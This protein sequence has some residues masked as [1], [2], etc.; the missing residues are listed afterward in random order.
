MEDKTYAVRRE[1]LTNI[2]QRFGKRPKNIL[3]KEIKDRGVY[4]I[5]QS[6]EEVYELAK[7]FSEYHNIPFGY[8]EPIIKQEDEFA[9]FKVDENVF[10]EAVENIEQD[11]FYI[12]LIK[13]RDNFSKKLLAL[14]KLIETY[15]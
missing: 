9:S 1:I 12:S 7:K 10:N 4:K 3:V 15:K 8:D 13:E 2:L 14:N 5:Q 11:L 6:D